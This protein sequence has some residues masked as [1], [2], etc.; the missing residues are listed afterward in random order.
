MK[1]DHFDT[2]IE[3]LRGEMRVFRDEMKE[4]RE[5][6]KEIREMVEQLVRQTSVS[7]SDC[8]SPRIL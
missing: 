2:V 1:R 5:E 4:I 7:P 8:E 6:M 3:E